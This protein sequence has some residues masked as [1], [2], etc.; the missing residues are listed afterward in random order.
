[1]PQEASGGDDAY[2]V[3]DD[4]DV[5]LW[6]SLGSGLSK[7]TDDRRVGVEEIYRQTISSCSFIRLVVLGCYPY[8]HGSCR[9][10]G[11]HRQ[12]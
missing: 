9:A 12:G 4:K 10:Y 8:R 1:M 11:G 5:G 3:G 7:V 2:G 6:R